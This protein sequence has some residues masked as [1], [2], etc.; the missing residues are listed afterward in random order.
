MCG[1]ALISSELSA[2]T[3]GANLH[4]LLIWYS[5]D[6]GDDDVDDNDIEKD[7]V[8]DNEDDDDEERGQITLTPILHHLL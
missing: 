3:Q 6:D 2:C 8:D 1:S 7:K 4:P 5:R